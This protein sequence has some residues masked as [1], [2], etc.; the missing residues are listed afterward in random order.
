MRHPHHQWDH[1]HTFGQDVVR[2]GERPT[3]IVTLLTAGMTLIE[4]AAGLAFGSMALLADGLH[5][6]SHGIALGIA[7]AGYALTRRY[8][9][10]PNFSFGTG[11]INALAAFTSALLLAVFAAGML[12]ESAERLVR[13]VAIAFDQALIVAVAGLLVNVISAGIL[14][15]P[16]RHERHA[17]HDHG[18]HNLRAA[19]VHVLADSVTSLLVIGALLIGRQFGVIWFDPLMGIVGAALIFRWSWGLLA[20]TGA[21]L[22]DRQVP[23]ATRERLRAAIEI[24]DSRISDLHIW[25]VGPRIYAAEMTI[26]SHAPHQP[27]DYKARIPEDL[28][29]V[30]ATVEVQ[31]CTADVCRQ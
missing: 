3:R 10:D 2:R 30:H 17:H 20:E 13:P 12:W 21:V 14:A 7:L 11:K 23:A 15:V 25:S 22:L 8:A 31:Y 6:A 29:I 1:Q 27:D 9:R 16:H 4:V 18:D 24:D 5:M 19:Y 26:I 28:R